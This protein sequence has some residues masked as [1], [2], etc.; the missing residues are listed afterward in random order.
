MEATGP[1]QHYRTATAEPVGH[2]QSDYGPSLSHF[3]SPMRGRIRGSTRPPRTF[4]RQ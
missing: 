1:P 4:S 2:F 3:G